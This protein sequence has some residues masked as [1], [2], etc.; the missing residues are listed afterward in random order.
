MIRVLIIL[1]VSSLVN[2]CSTVGKLFQDSTNEEALLL[3]PGR[4]FEKCLILEERQP[5]VFAFESSQDLLFD[6]HFHKKKEVLYPLPKMASS[7]EADHL[8]SNDSGMYCFLWENNQSQ[9]VDLTYQ[10]HLLNPIE[11]A[12][13]PMIAVRYQVDAD[14]RSIIIRNLEKKEIA[15][16]RV[17]EKILN[18]EI[19][20]N[21]GKMLVITEAEEPTLHLYDIPTQKRIHTFHPPIL[22]RFAAFSSDN[23]YFTVGNEHARTL[24]LYEVEKLQQTSHLDLPVVPQG[25]RLSEIDDHLLVRSTEEVVKIQFEPFSIL[26]R[27]AKIPLKIGDEIIMDNPNE[28]CFVHGV[29]HPLF[30]PPAIAM[31]KEG[32]PGRFPK[33]R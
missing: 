26:K 5:V 18:F 33:G 21:N 24:Y 30:I 15:R 32:L 13:S 25:I 14:L 2:S 3:P 19:D 29:P 28:W 22:P 10:Y 17:E 1:I 23:R 31:S 4:F 9:P 7:I 20:H 12:S 8:I 11:D 16:I 27:H 6:I